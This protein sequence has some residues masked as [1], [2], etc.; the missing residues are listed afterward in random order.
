MTNHLTRRDFLKLVGA[1]AAATAVLTGCGPAWRYVVRT[2]YLQMPEY[3]YNGQSTYYASTCRECPAG[4]GIV[5]R[6]HQGRAIKIEGNPN[7]PVNHGKLCARGQT[8]LQGLYNPDRLKKPFR[9]NGRDTESYTTL[10][11]DEAVNVIKD[12]LGN[13]S[14]S[15]VAFLLGLVPDHLSD[16]IGEITNA[17][18][19]TAPLRYSA[20]GYLESRKTLA[21]AANKVLGQQSL[22]VFDIGNSDVTFS[23]G[24]DFL[25]TWLSPVAFTRG[26]S[27]LR[28][29]T[30]G[31]RGYL[32]Q[33]EPRMSQTAAKADEWISIQPGSEGQVALA[34]GRLISE[35]RGGTLPE[36]FLNVDV[37][38]AATVS[39]V[40][41]ATLNRLAGIFSKASAPLAIAGGT[42]LATS[43]GFETAQAV[44]MLDALVDNLGKPGGIAF[45]PDLPVHPEGSRVLNTF[46]D[47]MELVARM[48]AGQIQVLFMHGINPLFEFPTALGFKEALAN[49]PLVI[50]FASFP[51]ESAAQSDFVFPDHH[52]LESWGYQIPVPAADRAVISASQPTVIPFYNTHATADVLLAA[53]QAI[54]G[55]LSKAVPYKDEV[56][57]LQHSVVGL[58][59]ETG[60]FNAPEINT[61]WAEWQQ[62]GGW[63]TPDAGLTPPN[64]ATALASSLSLPAATFEGA[65]DL[66]LHVY[67]STLMGDGNGANKPWLQEAPDPLTTVMWNSWVE[68]NPQTADKLGLHDDDLVRIVSDQGEVEASVYRYPAIRPDMIAMPFGQG[69]TAYGQYAESRGSNPA[70]LFPLILNSA[71][72]L[73][74]GAV[75]VRIEKTGQ[76]RP[77]ARNESRLGVYGQE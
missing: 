59:S 60:F 1:S 45:T 69:H 14:S 26:Y 24:A 53:V 18:G 13:H 71:G 20:F 36:V 58:V 64:A 10:S 31:R 72:D 2:P 34:L 7:H 63:W 6:T 73:A 76:T 3:T 55:D 19:I 68:I 44:L 30:P 49:V 37:K 50:S 57:F 12:A 56:E 35:L 21:E 41:M 33:F 66:F 42:A 22:P 46:T 62:N 9:Q 70:R 11:W 15:E 29:G 17:L 39:G 27:S 43:N 48:K 75:K 32:V 52:P 4:C 77:L 25:G 61:F 74:F 38:A 51:D 65:G 67:P 23:F 8:A 28:Q 54:G 47:L 40:D 5:V 16:L